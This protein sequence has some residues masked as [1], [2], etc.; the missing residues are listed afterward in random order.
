MR[1]FPE[2]QPGETSSYLKGL[3]GQGVIEPVVRSLKFEA[4][5]M[6]VRVVYTSQLEPAPVIPSFADTPRNAR[7]RVD[8]ARLVDQMS[9]LPKPY[10]Q[11]TVIE[12]TLI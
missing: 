8:L 3:E 11:T 6:G 12:S 5:R 7:K 1:R 9:G 10:R 2:G 4:A